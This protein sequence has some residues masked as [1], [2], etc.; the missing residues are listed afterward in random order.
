V[1]VIYTYSYNPL[2]NSAHGRSYSIPVKRFNPFPGN[3]SVKYM[4]VV[5][6]SLSLILN[7][8]S[9]LIFGLIFQ[10]LPLGLTQSRFDCRHSNLLGSQSRFNPYVR[11]LISAS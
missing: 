2:A 10:R 4:F 3:K 6:S 7:I 11:T 9:L 5:Y 8:H 1:T